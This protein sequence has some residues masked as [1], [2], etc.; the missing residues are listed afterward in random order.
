MAHHSFGMRIAVSSKTVSA[1]LR[2]SDMPKPDDFGSVRRPA[3]SARFGCHSFAGP[4]PPAIS[5]AAAGGSTFYRTS[6]RVDQ[7]W[8]DMLDSVG[9]TFADPADAL[10]LKT[11]ARYLRVG[12]LIRLARF[13]KLTCRLLGSNPRSYGPTSGWPTF[14]PLS[15]SWSLRGDILAPERS[16]GKWRNEVQWNKIR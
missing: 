5:Q 10:K 13:L 3:Q 7:N 4:L 14:R 15:P 12:S 16:P 2:G 9:E 8:T 1:A 11:L 6:A